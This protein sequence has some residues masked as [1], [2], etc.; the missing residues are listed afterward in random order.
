MKD[1]R[2]E[3]YFLLVAFRKRVELDVGPILEA[4]AIEPSECGDFC[5]PPFHPR[6]TPK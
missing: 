1:G 6:R 3:L 5:V 4:H 2:N